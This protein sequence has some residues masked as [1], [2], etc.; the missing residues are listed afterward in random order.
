MVTLDR[1]LLIGRDVGPE[2][3][4]VDDPYV[5][6]RHA[7]ILWLGAG[8]A[9]RDLRSTNGTRVN[10]V[11]LEGAEARSLNPDDQIQIGSWTLLTLAGV[12]RSV[13]KS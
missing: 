8:W 6:R 12:L 5:S 13:E 9:V 4:Q 1:P 3:I 7:E 2:H 10:G 11:A